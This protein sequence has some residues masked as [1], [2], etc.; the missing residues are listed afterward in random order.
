MNTYQLEKR[1]MYLEI[2]YERLLAKH[3]YLGKTSPVAK[4]H[5]ELNGL[6]KEIS[7]LSRG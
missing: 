7:R 4:L 6:W 2:K 3:N 1:A 5:E